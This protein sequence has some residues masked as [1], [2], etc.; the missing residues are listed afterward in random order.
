MTLETN[1]VTMLQTK[2]LQFWKMVFIQS[3][4]SEL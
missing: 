3:E 4:N 2:I 1:Y